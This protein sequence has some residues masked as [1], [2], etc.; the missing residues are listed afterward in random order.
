MAGHYLSVPE[1][2]LAEALLATRSVLAAIGGL[3]APAMLVM[4]V[5]R[6]ARARM[7]ARIAA[8]E[9]MNQKQ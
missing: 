8:A 9:A 3:A 6:A 2:A 5:R 4:G 7:I 1:A